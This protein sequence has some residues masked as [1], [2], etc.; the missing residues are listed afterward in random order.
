MFWLEKWC[1]RTKDLEGVYQLQGL[2]AGG[3]RD[4]FGR[5]VRNWTRGAAACSD[6]LD[7]VGSSPRVDVRKGKSDKGV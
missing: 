4:F 2:M 7:L 3:V 1:L 6:I 5:G